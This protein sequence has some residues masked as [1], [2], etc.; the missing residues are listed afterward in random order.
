MS[1]V[2]KSH[3]VARVRSKR[4][5][6]HYPDVSSVLWTFGHFVPSPSSHAE[7]YRLAHFSPPPHSPPKN[8]LESRH[9]FIYI[10]F[11]VKIKEEGM[12]GGALSPLEASLLRRSAAIA[13]GPAK[14]AKRKEATLPS[15]ML[16]TADDEVRT[17]SAS[18]FFR[19]TAHRLTAFFSLHPPP[20]RLSSAPR[21]FS[22][23]ITDLIIFHVVLGPP[24]APL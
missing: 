14:D 5:N 19:T 3:R 2:C 22:P 24:R 11:C 9:F 17:L 13:L 23:L 8:I 18:S 16:R 15:D 7:V 6:S 4:A 10:F 20:H 1:V 21:P 12:K